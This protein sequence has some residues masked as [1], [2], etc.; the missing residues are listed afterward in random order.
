MVDWAGVGGGMEPINSVH[1]RYAHTQVCKIHQSVIQKVYKSHI[2]AG[3]TLVLY[4]HNVLAHA[5]LDSSS[6]T[7]LRSVLGIYINCL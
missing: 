4:I 1:D 2:C 5:K 6:S 7:I 3:S